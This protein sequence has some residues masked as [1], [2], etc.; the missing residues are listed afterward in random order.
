MSS[1]YDPIVIDVPEENK[2]VIS[3]LDT[4]KYRIKHTDEIPLPDTV[5]SFNGQIVSTRKN[6][7]GITGKAKVGKS[8][9]MTLINGAV[10]KKG[11]TG[12]LASYL[13]KGKDKILYIDTEQS[14]FHVSLVL[15]RIKEIAEENRM[16]NLLMYA[17]DSVPTQNRFDYTEF[18]IQNTKDIGLVIIDGIADLVKTVNDEIIACDMADTLRRW[19]TVQDVAIGYVLHQNP[20]DNAKMRGHLGTVLMNKS[21]TVVQIS[22]SKEN[23][24]VKL[25]ETTQ[26]RNKKPDNWSFEIINGTPVI[27]DQCYSEPKAGRK[28]VVKLTDINRYELLN[29]VFAG[30][31]KAQGISPTVLMENITDAYSDKYGPIGETKI[32]Q[33]QNYCKEKKWLVQPDGPRTNY[34]L[35]DFSD[36]RGSGSRIEY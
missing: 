35:Y 22:S 11:E 21:E 4:E 33:F 31:P 29:I 34:F 18:L 5:L 24:S 26:T 19:A 9:L 17:F 3:F 14:D 7:F 20:S 32:K 12:V 10:L 23:E 8:F 13:P 15:K 28:P 27:M 2:K 30:V 16:D 36:I 6:I 1:M 25:V